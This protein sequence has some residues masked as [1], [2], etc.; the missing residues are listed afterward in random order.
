[1][2]DNKSFWSRTA[3]IYGWFTW[4]GKAAKGAYSETEGKIAEHLSKEMNVLELAAG[5]GIFS[6]RIA[7]NCNTLE[8]TDFSPEMIAQARKKALPPNVTF[9][10][11]DA[12]NLRYGDDT[13]D[14]VVI[15][16]ALHIMP[17]PARAIEEIKRVLKDNGIMIAP[18]F[19]RENIRYYL[20][21]WLMEAFGFKTFSRWTHQTYRDFLQRQG[22]TVS[23]EAVITGHNFSISFVVCKQGSQPLKT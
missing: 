14:A 10:V 19:T 13:F 2:D 11:A 20:V 9:A 21:E 6:G 5:P 3:R 15:A 22:M 17:D 1:M 4:G 16:N 12:T 18:T 8:V 7:E 23:Y